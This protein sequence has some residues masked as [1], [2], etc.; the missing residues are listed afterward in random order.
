V[1]ESHPTI[2][3]DIVEAMWM[4]EY[5]GEII[6]TAELVGLRAKALAKHRQ[7]IEEIQEWVDT[8]KLDAVQCYAWEHEGTIKDYD[9][10]PGDMVLI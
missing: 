5:L 3:L 10:Q 6:S 4:V 1:T 9:F 2:P 7:H 8:E